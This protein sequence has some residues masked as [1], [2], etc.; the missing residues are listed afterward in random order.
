MSNYQK[1]KN[2]NDEDNNIHP[3]QRL[4]IQEKQRLFQ[5][6]RT[7]V[8]RVVRSNLRVKRNKLV[9]T[10]DTKESAHVSATSFVYKALRKFSRPIKDAEFRRKVDPF[11]RLSTPKFKLSRNENVKKERNHHFCTDRPWFLG[12]QM[13][14]ICSLPPGSPA[15]LASRYEHCS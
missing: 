9:F 7:H 10:A 12:Y 2:N 3:N 5:L 6:Y 11:Y 15:V 13:N 1:L 14:S 4:E 8:N